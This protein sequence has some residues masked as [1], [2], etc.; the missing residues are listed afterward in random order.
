MIVVLSRQTAALRNDF[1]L[2]TDCVVPAALVLNLLIFRNLIQAQTFSK[3][4]SS[5]FVLLGSAQVA[6][7]ALPRAINTEQPAPSAGCGAPES[8][9]WAR[10]H[11]SILQ[12]NPRQQELGSSNMNPRA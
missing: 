1:F 5:L 12:A 11:S 3:L 7:T 10:I 2:I 6:P 8:G 4:A 9:P